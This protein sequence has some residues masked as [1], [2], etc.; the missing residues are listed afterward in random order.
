[1]EEAPFPVMPSW[2]LPALLT[3][4]LTLLTSALG[5]VW[6]EIKASEARTG[7]RLDELREDM[8]EQRSDLKALGAKVD[9]LVESVLVAR[10][11]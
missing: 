10:Q 2:L 4:G 3:G 11:S 8:R 5:M 6:L 1:M 7:K 9:R